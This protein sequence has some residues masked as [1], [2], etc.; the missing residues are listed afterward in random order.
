MA[1]FKAYDIRG[2]VPDELDAKKAYSIG[3]A[4]ASF[5]GTGPIAVGRDA[6]IH[7]PELTRALVDGIR[8][9]G[10]DV[11]DVGMVATPMLYFGVEHLGAEAGVM[12]TASHN[13]GEYNGFKICRAHA[14][15]VGEA[16][17]LR[18]IEALVSE[19]AAAPRAASRGALSQR[20]IVVAYA[21]H[22]LSVGEHRPPLKIAIDCG[23]GMASVGLLPVLEALPVDVVRLYFEPDGS[24]PNHEADPLKLENLQDVCE[25]VRREGA[26]FGVAFDGDGDRAVFVDGGGEPISA[27]LATALIARRL[28]KRHAGARV[29][30]DLRSSRVVAQ[31]IERG[32]G[33]AGICRVGH[34]FVKAQMREEGAI[35]AGE[36]SGHL[37]FRFSKDLIADDGIAALVALLDV[38]GAEG[39]P[40]AELIE[41]LRC[42]SASGE[43]NRRVADADFVIESIAAEHADAPELSRLDGLLV[44]Y[45]TWW[46]NIRASNTEPVLRLNLEADT[47]D[48]MTRRRDEILGKIAVLGER[49]SS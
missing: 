41:P 34:S 46:F 35:F 7:S 3:R 14:V 26:D 37:Y 1:L 18:E 21:D 27:D 42:Y 45:A 32:G 23:N 29:L 2:V 15:P 11:L 10:V 25:A 33:D 16:S 47:D 39:R 28:L 12:V 36:L 17:G 31:E 40:L 20:E 4:I 19:R 38:L 43:I 30:Y 48:E 44:R 9:E 5:I 8:D 49:G 6:R 24:F 13:P 22:A